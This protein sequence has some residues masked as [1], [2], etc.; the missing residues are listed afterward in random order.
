[1][2]VRNGGC[3]KLADI[4]QTIVNSL[5]SNADS[6]LVFDVRKKIKNDVSTEAEFTIP[7]AGAD[8]AGDV[9]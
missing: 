6:G 8:E 1:M 5:G 3:L 9:H 4:G 2:N 7:A